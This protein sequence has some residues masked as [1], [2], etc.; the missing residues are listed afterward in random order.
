MDWARLDLAAIA[1]TLDATREAKLRAGLDP[2]P[3]TAADVSRRVLE[4]YRH[5]DALLADRVELFA[6]GGSAQILE[7]NLRVLCGVTP[8]RRVAFADHV[9][10]TRA[11]FYDRPGQ[12][13]DALN[14]WVKRHRTASPRVFVAGLIVQ[15]V[16][17]P[18]LFIEG[19][20][21]TST[22][23]ASY[24]LARSGLPPLVV[25]PDRIPDYRA[26][27]EACGSIER[28]GGLRSRMARI[29]AVRRTAA[30]IDALADPRFLAATAHSLPDPGG[31]HS[32]CRKAAQ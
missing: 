21:R 32:G 23:L 13:V 4:G 2:T 30:L 16:A 24:V 15:V 31:W 27:M 8:E 18:Q 28:T 11:R 9:E 19:N 22:L 14:D 20:R 25:P 7:L 6:Y 5:V 26:V 17:T 12:G 10:A 29:R 3:E 1:S